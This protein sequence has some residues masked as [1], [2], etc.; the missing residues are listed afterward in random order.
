MNLRTGRIVS[1]VSLV[2]VFALAASVAGFAQVPCNVP[3]LIYCQTWDGGSNL[4]AS[5][6]DTNIG[7]F[8]NFA[9]TYDHFF[10]PG[11]Q[12]WDVESFHFV[13]GYFNPPS[14]GPITAWGLTFYA[15][16][17]GIPG[18]PIY[19]N[20]LFGT[21][22]E[23]FLGNVNGFPIYSYD[24]YFISFDMAPGIYWASVV[25]DLG[26]PPQWGWATSANGNGAGY[27]CFFGTCGGTGTNLAFAVDGVP[28]TTPE[29]GTLVMLGTGILGLAGVLR[30]KINL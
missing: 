18:A 13:G 6:N 5:Q 4:F 14:Q 16:N 19:F 8:G 21:G 9:T 26:F 12:T 10:L 24:L 11:N 2:A 25:P 27:Q 15:D 1:L 17:A 22:N 20:S 3:N 30:R 7:G 28:V 23:T 29:P